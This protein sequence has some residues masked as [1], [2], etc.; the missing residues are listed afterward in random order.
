MTLSDAQ[1]LVLL[2]SLPLREVVEARAEVPQLPAKD[3]YAAL[4]HRARDAVGPRV[5]R[6][7]GLPEYIESVEYCSGWLL[8]FKFPY[9]LTSQNCFDLV[10]GPQITVQVLSTSLALELKE[11]P[12]LQDV[13]AVTGQLSKE[14]L[15][16]ALCYPGR[17]RADGL[18]FLDLDLLLTE[19]AC[20][21][22]LLQASVASH[23]AFMRWQRSLGLRPPP[24][25]TARI[26]CEALDGY[27]ALDKSAFDD[28]CNYVSAE[29]SEL[30]RFR[31]RAWQALNGLLSDAWQTP[32]LVW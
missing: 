1:A 29:D 21:P 28:L 11:R 7:L 16:L 13:R 5:L 17:C 30:C 8:A 19:P 20:E 24:V 6:A 15:A 26:M 27:E 25:V 2:Y 4:F 23:K 14:R 9:V 3:L 18:N 32:A 10:D 12:Q 22:R 31:F